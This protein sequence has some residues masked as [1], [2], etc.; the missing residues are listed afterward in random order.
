MNQLKVKGIILR[1]ES[2]GYIENFCKALIHELKV[3]Y[4]IQKGETFNDIRVINPSEMDEE[5]LKRKF[6][7]ELTHCLP[8]DSTV[9][10]LFL[11]IDNFSDL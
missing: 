3:S 7:I 10:H 4:W 11:L 5:Y 6:N 1:K 9:E 8:P 2:P